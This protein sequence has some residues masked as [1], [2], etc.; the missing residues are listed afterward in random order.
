MAVGTFGDECLVLNTGQA[1]VDTTSGGILIVAANG[2]RRSLVVTNTHATIT[3]YI[4]GASGVSSSNGQA[5]P[6]GQSISFNFY[7]GAVWGK[8]AS[9]S[10]TATYAE[11]AK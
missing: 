7:I 2:Q 3:M 11:E 4:G 6:A 9:S 8:S 1:T 5:V 10:V